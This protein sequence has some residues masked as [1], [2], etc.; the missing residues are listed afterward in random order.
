MMTEVMT[1]EE[2]E[3]IG[4]MTREDKT[5]EY[6]MTREDRTMVYMMT[7]EDKIT[8]REMI[9]EVVT[10][11]KEVEEETEEVNSST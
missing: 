6:M 2:T 11:G 3:T 9:A 8:D 1:T 7:R 10:E 4:E 5:T